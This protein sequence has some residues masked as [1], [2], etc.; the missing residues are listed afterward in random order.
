MINKKGAGNCLIKKVLNVILHLCQLLL[1]VGIILTYV[2]NLKLFISI[3]P[4]LFC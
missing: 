4:I 3:A 1:N 2:H